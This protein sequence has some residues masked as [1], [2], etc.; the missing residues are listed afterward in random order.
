M[1]CVNTNSRK[2]K[3]LA[4]KNNVDINALELI[5]HKYWLEK[6]SEEFFPTDVYIQAQ[7]GNVQ[8]EEHGKAIQE[9]WKNNYST[10]QSFNSL[11][12]LTATQQE[13]R[14]YFPQHALV[15]YKDAKGKYVLRVKQPVKKISVTKGLLD[16]G[17]LSNVARIDLGLQS[18]ATYGIDKV[19]ELFE[20]FNQDRTSKFLADKVF[21]AAKD[22]GLKITFDDSIS[23]SA[24]G[25]YT[26]D[27]TI[28]FNK[29]FFERDW[30]NNKKSSILLHE[31]IHA[32]TMYAL[33]DKT[34]GWQKPEAVQHF[35]NEI[36]SIFQDV[37]NNAALE[38]ER[39]K[40]DVKE[41]VAELANPVFRKKLQ[42]IDKGS[43]W[44]RLVNAI[45]SFL[46][47]KTA[48]TYY[49]RAMN[50]LDEALDAF[51]MDTY[52]KYTKIGDILQQAY[53][54]ESIDRGLSEAEIKQSIKEHY[55]NIL[56]LA[57]SLDENTQERLKKARQ[58]A[59]AERNSFTYAMETEEE[60]DQVD[61]VN[62]R[63]ESFKKDYGDL[64]KKIVPTNNRRGGIS[65]SVTLKSVKEILDDLNAPVLSQLSMIDNMSKDDILSN[66]MLLEQEAADY[67][68]INGENKSILDSLYSDNPVHTT[69][70]GI[71]IPF[72]VG[73][74]IKYPE[75]LGG[76]TFVIK[77]FIEDGKDYL[78]RGNHYD[79]YG[80]FSHEE[81]DFVGNILGVNSLQIFAPDG[82]N[83]THYKSLSD[84][85]KEQRDKLQNAT[86]IW[87]HPGTGKTW[88]YEHGRKDIIDFDSEYKSRL[89]NLQEREVL[90]N[91]I[92]KEAYN[93]KLDELFKEAKTEAL[94]TG[95]KLLVSDMHFLRDRSNDLDVVTNISDAEFI[96]RSHQRGEHNESDK[97]EWKNSINAAMKNVPAEKIIN[98]TGYISDLL[99]QVQQIKTIEE[100]YNQLKDQYTPESSEAKLTEAVFNALKDTGVVFKTSDL[101]E[102]ISGRYVASDN[103]ILYNP[104]ALQDSTLLHE[105]IHAVTSYYLEAKNTNGFSNEIKAAIQEINECYDLLK[106]DYIDEYRK[107]G[108]DLES[109]FELFLDNDTYGYTSPKEMVAELGKPSFVDHIKDFDRRHKGQ[110]IFKRLKDAIL[111]LLGINK[112]YGSLESTLKK[113]VWTLI[114]TPSK[115]LMQRYSQENA[116]VKKN[117]K[118]LRESDHIK[119]E[120]RRAINQM[121]DTLPEDASMVEYA[122]ATMSMDKDLISSSFVLPKNSD[123]K[124]LS[125]LK[126]GTIFIYENSLFM[127]LNGTPTLKGETVT[128]PVRVYS[129]K[130]LTLNNLDIKK[131]NNGIDYIAEVTPL[132]SVPQTSQQ[133]IESK[134]TQNEVFQETELHLP[135]YVALQKQFGNKGETVIVDAAWKL[136]ILQKLDEMMV[137]ETQEGK[138]NIADEIEEILDATDETAYTS[139][140]VKEEKKT[141]RNLS[142]FERLINQFN[143]LLDS[144]LISAS[145]IRHVAE[146][147]V[148]SMS[149]IITACQTEEG[150]VEQR[151]PN[152]NSSIDF[153]KASRRDIVETLG[154]NRLVYLT[155]DLFKPENA[156]YE[157]LQTMMQAQLIIDN[158]DAV[159]S[160]ASDIF[161]A[162]EGF[163]ITAN[164]DKGGFKLADGTD[165]DYDNFNEQRDTETVEENYGDEQEHWQIESRTID[166]LNSMSQLVRLALHDCYQLDKDGKQV[167]SKWGIAERVNPRKAVN[168]ILR[169]TQGSQSLEDMIKHLA[170]RQDKQPWVSQLINRLSDQ[171]GKEAD[172]QSQFYGVFQKHFQPY[173]IVLL[174]DGKY[175]S[176]PV[177]NHPAL[178]EAMASVTTQY[179]VGEHPLFTQRGINSKLLGSEKTTSAK[180]EMNLH[181]TLAAL[182][183]IQ[184]GLSHGEEFG[185]QM[186]EEA[187]ANIAAASKILG[188]P[189]GEEMLSDITNQENVTKM[190]KALRFIVSSLDQALKEQQRNPNANYNPFAYNGENSIAGS[191][192]NFLSPITDIL[193][194]TA[195]N[196]FYDSGK[197][198]QSYVTPSFMTKLMNKFRLEGQEF[199][200]FIMN[201]YGN[202]E[203]FKFAGAPNTGW[204]NE[205][206]RQLARD[207]EAR[208]VFDH[209]VELNFNKHNYMRNMSDAEYTLSLITEYL[210]EGNANNKNLVPAWFRVPIQSNKPSSEFIKFY[211]YRGETYKDEIVNGLYNMFLQELSRI[212]TVRMR[213]LS[214]ND[215]DFIKNFDSNGR[216]FNFLPFLNEYLDGRVGNLLASEGN[217]KRLAQLLQKKINGNKKLSSQEEATL[218]KLAQEAIRIHMEDRTS[219]I[220]D[221]WERNGILE[222]AKSIKGID[223]DVS[224][225]DIIENFLW[226]DNFASKNILQLTVGDIA[227]YKDAED[228]QKRLAQLHAPG[229]R[230]NINA[231][232]YNGDKVSDGKYRTF[233]LKDFDNFKSN[234]IANISEVFDKRIAA[235]PD[236]QKAQLKALKESLVGKDGKY[237][238]INVADAQGYSSPSSYRKKA[239]IFGRW[240]REAE[241]IY[242]KL[243][244]GKYNYTDLETAFQPLKPFVYSH[245]QKDMGVNN[246]P[247][248]TMPVPFQA[249]NAEYLL[250]MADA[251]LKGEKLSRPNLLR[252]V[253]RAMEESERLNPTKGI[254]T[255]QFESAI[256]SGLQGRIDINQFTDPVGGEEAAY[257]Y[258]MSQLYKQNPDGTRSKEYNTTTFVHEASYEDYCLQQ[259]V[260]AHF[261]NHAQAHGSQIRMI[262]P[263]DLDLYK[264]PNGDL[265]AEDN[266]VYYEWTEP[267]GTA[268]KVTA[269][270]FKKEYEKTIADNIQQS[271]NELSE[272]LH[273]NSLDKKEQNIAL[274]KILQREILSS[275]RYGVD[276]IQACSI[277]KETG[278]F[279]IPK[280]DPIQAKRIEQLINSIIKN[281]VNKQKI[282]GGPIVQVSNFGTSK[283]LHI[284][285]NDKNGNLLMTEEEFKASGKQGTYKQY[286]KDNQA[287]IAYFE[288]FAPM[289]SEDIFK[290]FSNKDGSINVEAIEATNPELLKMI[291]YRI[292]TE[293]KYSMAPTKIVGF[294]PREAGDAIMLPY[295]L[296]EID[297]SDFDVDKRYVMRKDIPIKRRKA[298]EIEQ[299]LLDKLSESYSKAHD[300]KKAN[301]Y[302]GEQVRMFINNPEK[303]KYTDSLMEAL[304]KE[305]QRIAYYTEAPTSGRT[306]RDNKIID[307]TWAV[308]TNEMTADKILNPGGFDN[309]KKVAYQIAA[310][311]EGN[312]SWEQLQQMSIDELKELSSIDKDLSWADTQVHFYRQNAAGSNLIGVFAVNK[313]AH[314][315]L[316]SNDILLAV[317]EICGEEPFTIAGMTFGG[318][319][320]LDPKYDINGNLIGKTIGSGVSA[321]ADTAKEPTLDLINVNM[322][323]AGIFNA[324]Q[325]LGMPMEDAA[326]VMAQ[327][328]ITKVL[329]EFNRKNL[330]DY[331]P[332]SRIVEKR[333]AEIRDQ[334]NIDENSNINTEPLTREELVEGLTDTEHDVIDYKVLSAFQKLRAIADAVRKPTFA[335]RFNSMASAV[336]PLIIDNLIM[337]HKMQQFSDGNS[338]DKIPFYN[339]KGQV[340]D[341]NSIFEMHPILQQFAQTVNVAASM[342]DDMPMG[343]TQF[344]SLLNRIPS[345]MLEKFYNDR[346]LLDKLGN[347]YQS[348]L[349]IASKFIN[350]EQ[351]SNYINGFPA[352]FM[353]QNYKEKYAGN[354]LIEAIKMNVNKKTGRP[355]LTINITGAD[356]QVKESLGN[357]WI[358]LHKTD[359]V[360]SE[361]L[362]N[363]C[364]FRAGV[365]FSPKTFM[366]LVPTY[367]KEKL[368]RTLEDGTTTSYVDT[369]RVFPQIA[370]DL[371]IDQF[372]RNNW[373]NNKLVPNK[374][375]KGTKYM[376]DMEK[377]ILLATDPNDLADLKGVSYMKTKNGGQTILWKFIGEEADD[378]TMR[379]YQRVKP[380][381]N[382]GEYLEMSLNDIQNPLANTT[383]TT[384]DVE[385]SEMAPKVAAETEATESAEEI[386]TP[387]E[388]SKEMMEF[389]DLVMLQ[390]ESIGRPISK[391]EAT[392]RVYD[393]MKNPESFGNYMVN[394]FKQKGLTL[395]KEEAIKEFKKMC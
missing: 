285:F 134:K 181:K 55:L 127:A 351:L 210:A 18:D 228:L 86:V 96:E 209:K 386:K 78:I 373:T 71:T 119:V 326:L 387:N 217:N 185:T 368:N 117:H 392:N 389:V 63:I 152:L 199:E 200:D 295:E 291:S 21:R 287:G 193:E 54:Q 334:Y 116:N 321:S 388:L 66:M 161:A 113:A 266:K 123:V 120:N 312:V 140:E 141:Q 61:R 216:K 47:I 194:D 221:N 284:R 70:D 41:F 315:T 324:I 234:L 187:S 379:T 250:I 385:I 265:T 22:L 11:E 332:L 212:Q 87:A 316:E 183:T 366:S 170:E 50:A 242:Q 157:D 15:H 43:F 238:K 165:I 19:Q 175:T 97:R 192:R 358:D 224:A 314:A 191:L 275:P 306:Y 340:V 272:E 132:F 337:E 180:D 281:R 67:D 156:N 329:S 294:M 328:A 80:R 338:T 126:Q 253:Y 91:K 168:S 226:N 90:K 341:I 190:T 38:S 215:A 131:D 84:Q 363:Y 310:F 39:G 347:F 79:R 395:S 115:E 58:A 107:K 261:K 36:N 197:M 380:L 279:R 327:S 88:M 336:G 34:Q 371:V 46:G 247:I 105:A 149:D 330:V 102:D 32:M 171:S 335:T 26:N 53:Q 348:Y 292:P 20:K 69:D 3:E 30:M 235:A 203:W 283:Q 239:F 101:G 6:G 381:G 244:R 343:S 28:K 299:M 82:T 233:I 92:G 33:S 236:D 206:L 198:Y 344:R 219:R 354:E 370:F 129:R 241:D 372:I 111:S 40:T 72:A 300:G 260:P 254:D 48:S 122:D 146:L 263:S 27:N 133:Q 56:P 207:P 25:R 121:L 297:D 273:F 137:G 220:L 196:A 361:R 369:Y 383:K 375:G 1:G 7:L 377:G 83:I 240:S 93:K 252:A 136:P 319:M 301:K 98:T 211:S 42:S 218:L 346:T 103:T 95:R 29:A 176:I 178:T 166:V 59:N 352:W 150:F 248:H 62:K 225:R 148:N 367:V 85:K 382:N 256:K 298:S 65:Y 313:V 202:S 135:N 307:M 155:K 289:W 205:W 317:D 17:F 394:V 350:P 345:S 12:E 245:L 179:K 2:F 139:S 13:A 142:N 109:G 51:D 231:I 378:L 138:L 108:I 74:K 270:E 60:A 262:V 349:L 333:L 276:L 214:K 77:R 311:R 81:D 159:M 128:I 360:L 158:W 64:V 304:Y 305:Y 153:Q 222:A 286:V 390:R 208:K 227:F 353:K 374:G 110:N 249:K 391:S 359:P 184:D 145:E 16:N 376:V 303:M 355:Y 186:A 99:P 76:H 10:P 52:T 290:K 232:D 308:L 243:L 44:K 323:T 339:S 278:N 118:A 293:D 268:K 322:I 269:D 125:T 230:G 362:F 5:T 163:G 267:D 173:S 195:I 144:D 365:G 177:N 106:Q 325:R 49:N 14:K 318:R 288:A 35:A 259:E 143:N 73:V 164:Y 274:S 100:V 223:D 182:N 9:M 75:E 302:I 277:D 309:Y 57:T 172:F 130:G 162:N 8:Y 23:I 147:I 89:G 188:Y 320:Y 356:T 393:M 258:I 169:W 271:L 31:V 189:I 160:L 251:I 24:P 94:K 68:L 4:A 104:N 282:A 124:R 174:E 204:R 45:K 201:E 331:E 37:R 264:N 154:I 255:V 280:G 229:M 114:T 384:E 151:F 364:F 213:N 257:V 296:T 237:T 342:F 357:A 167:M 246:A 112:N